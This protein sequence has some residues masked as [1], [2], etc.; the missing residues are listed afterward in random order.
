MTANPYPIGKVTGVEIYRNDVVVKREGSGVPPTKAERGCI[1]VFSKK[2]RERLAFIAA[3]TS[4]EF[5]AMITLTYPAD[6]PSDGE[7]VKSHFHAMMVALRRRAKGALSHLWFIEFQRRGAPHFH[8][9]TRG[10]ATDEE[11]RRWLSQ[12]WYTIVGSNDTKHLRAGTRL[13]R[14][15]VQ[16]G[17]ARYAVKYCYKMKQK[18]V[19]RDYRNVGRF[20]GHSK[21]V[22]PEPI[23]EADCTAD[24]VLAALELHGW[25]YLNGDV[26]WYTVL[27]GTSQI[28]TDY[29]FGDILVLNTS[30]SHN[31]P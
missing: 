19:P 16:N 28:L 22:K 31:S 10:I 9:L 18:V 20:W 5:T 13:E 17:A 30:A 26:L 25:P 8:I 15:R 4:I 14:I 2:S 11:T 21:D 29:L 27:Y 1:A 6:Y 7:L 23:A 3:N 24:D 12:R